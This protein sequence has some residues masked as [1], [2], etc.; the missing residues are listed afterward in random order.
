M[1]SYMELFKDAFPRYRSNDDRCFA[2]LYDRVK[3]DY[4]EKAKWIIQ[5]SVHIEFYWVPI[6]KAYGVTKLRIEK[7]KELHERLHS[8]F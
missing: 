2:Y 1:K 8:P 5:I 6:T 7:L 4:Y 3:L